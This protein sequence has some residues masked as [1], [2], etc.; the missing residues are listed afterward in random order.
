MAP[1]KLYNSE[2]KAR[3]PVQFWNLVLQKDGED[4]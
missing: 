4:K 3:N 1:K 2:I